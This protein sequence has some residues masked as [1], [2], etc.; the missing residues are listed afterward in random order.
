MF[1]KSKNWSKIG[2]LLGIVFFVVA[3]FLW[4]VQTFYI[5]NKPDLE[6][7]I[8]AN[9]K[10][11]SKSEAFPKIQIFYDSIDIKSN[12]QSL[13][14]LSMRLRNDGGKGILN[15]Y[16]D[17]NKDFGFILQE[18]RLLY[19][20]T[21]MA[22]S[23]VEYYSEIF[24][25]AIGDTIILNKLI[26]DQG[27]YV[28]IQSIVLHEKDKIPMIKPIGK[29]AGIDSLKVNELMENPKFR[30]DFR[31][32]FLV[33]IFAYFLFWRDRIGNTFKEIFESLMTIL[34]GSAV[35]IFFVN[36]LFIG[37]TKSGLDGADRLIVLGG[38]CIIGS[39][40]ALLVSGMLTEYESTSD[41][42]AEGKD[43]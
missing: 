40:S 37:L 12:E 28:D 21:L 42:N 5:E 4:I 38:S 29:I 23:D 35:L 13:S 24:K 26:F 20:P 31:Y 41:K 33:G 15:S 30:L 34:F 10:I 1:T 27:S 39:F 32:T 6:F 7:L 43:G 19:P 9:E 36:L 8:L 17:V 25:E 2:T 3:T 18:G 22:A 11:F 16:Y 14:V